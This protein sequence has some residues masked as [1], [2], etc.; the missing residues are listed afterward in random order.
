VKE[1]LK[2]KSL[3]VIMF[4]LA[5]FTLCFAQ[6]RKTKQP[7]PPPPPPENPLQ[8]GRDAYSIK[9]YN[10]AMQYFKKITDKNPDSAIALYYIANT[11]LKTGD[12][13][14]GMLY[15]VKAIVNDSGYSDSLKRFNFNEVPFPLVKLDYDG[16]QLVTKVA[17]GLRFSGVIYQEDA[18][19]KVLND[20]AYPVWAEPGR[21]TGYGAEISGFYNPVS[22][23]LDYLVGEIDL[24]T[25]KQRFAL[26]PGLPDSYV[27][28]GGYDYKI[29]VNTINFNA[30]YTPMVMAWGLLYPSVGGCFAYSSYKH[31]QS[32]QNYSSLGI[33]L[34]LMIKY[35]NLFVKG[36]YKKGIINQTFDNQMSMQFGFKINMFN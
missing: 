9:D 2:I 1:I 11:F 3:L 12:Y 30:M 10:K 15:Y 35:K 17:N 14:K 25:V 8:I 33:S 26:P 29:S 27:G 5:G 13:D 24:K 20:V 4:L 36:G 34:E 28:S 6:T 19:E 23:S 32:K 22:L 16:N 18:S 21:V 31:N 7:P